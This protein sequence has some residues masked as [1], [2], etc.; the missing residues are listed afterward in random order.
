[1]RL[2]VT[3]GNGFI[4]RN[5]KDF[6]KNVSSSD[7]VLYTP[8]RIE[9]DLLDI[10]SVEREIIS[11]KPDVVI[12]T[13]T[14]DAVPTHYNKDPNKVLDNNL[15][16]FL[17]I[18]KCKHLYGRLINLGTGAEF[19]RSHWKPKMKEEDFGNYIPQDP[20]GFS[21]Y[22]TC[23][24]ADQ[25]D[26]ILHLRLFAV[27]GKYEDWRVRFLSNAICRNIY[28][29]P[30]RIN[31]NRVFDFLHIDDFIQ[32][33][34]HF[35][36]HRP[37][38]NI[39]NICSGN[40]YDFIDL[41]NLIHDISK[42]HTGNVILTGGLGSEYSGDNTLMSSEHQFAITPIKQ[43]LSDLYNWY[44]YEKQNIDPNLL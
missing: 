37:N 29:M 6:Y 23:K 35:I 43:S 41:A 22:I 3:G 20:Y 4:A 44:V 28:D 33:L 21:K 1:M 18:E 32:I 12:H 19:D 14:Y 36:R 24:I 5:I 38:H 31:Q 26:N 2:L 11:F 42:K 40:T 16:M 39:M 30:I 10:V 27:F 15:R 9:M 13:A 17:N 34:D 8:T 7:I 25:R